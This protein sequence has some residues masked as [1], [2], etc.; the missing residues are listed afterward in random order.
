MDGT[1][2][3]F[4]FTGFLK[5]IFN[6]I[7]YYFCFLFKLL[8]NHHKIFLKENPIYKGTF[9]IMQVFYHL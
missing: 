1:G 5:L 4:T 6:E 8:A 2:S 7:V 3:D 9:C